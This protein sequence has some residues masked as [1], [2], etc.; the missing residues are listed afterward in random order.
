MTSLWV[1]SIV[2]GLKKKITT[3][4]QL[5]TI[6]DSATNPNRLP[7]ADCWHTVKQQGSVGSHDPDWSEQSCGK[8]KWKSCGKAEWLIKLRKTETKYNVNIWTGCS[9]IL[10]K[11]H[12]LFKDAVITNYIIVLDDGFQL[13]L[14]SIYA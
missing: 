11:I 7:Q 13:F 3:Y 14:Q 9:T 10:S 12:I 5:S 8:V 1:R 4:L 6:R 2:S